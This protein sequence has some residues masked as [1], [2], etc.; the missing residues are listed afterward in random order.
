MLYT[1]LTRALLV[2]NAWQHILVISTPM[3]SLNTSLPRA[4]QI[5]EVDI[6]TKETFRE[7]FDG[8]SKSNKRLILLD[9]DVSQDR[10]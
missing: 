4:R 2:I 6:I 10:I 5:D 8:Y 1:T 7:I 9:H 3:C